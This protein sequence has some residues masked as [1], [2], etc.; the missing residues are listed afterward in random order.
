MG[1]NTSCAHAPAAFSSTPLHNCKKNMLS[2]EDN[3]IKYYAKIAKIIIMEPTNIPA[4]DTY[5]S[6]KQLHHGRDCVPQA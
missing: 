1:A 2:S 3:A 6:I 4:E 5:L